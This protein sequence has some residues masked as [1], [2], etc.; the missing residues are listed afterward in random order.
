[1]KNQN[2]LY[3]PVFVITLLFLSSC[4]AISDIIRFGMGVGLFIGV[5]VIVVMLASLL[6]ASR[7]KN[8]S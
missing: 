1:M 7:N 8:N 2:L 6:H 3:A 4:E 5:L